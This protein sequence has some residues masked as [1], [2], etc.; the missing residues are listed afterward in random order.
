MTDFGPYHMLSP[1]TKRLR[2]RLPDEALYALALYIYSLKPPLNPNLIDQ[3]SRAGQKIFEREGC[4]RCHTPPLYTNNKLTLAFGFTPG[5]DLSPMLD[6]SPVSVG[7]DPGLALKP[8]KARAT[9]RSRRSEASGTAA[10]ICTMAPRQVW[11]KC[12]IRIG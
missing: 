6:I 9:I 3:K 4:A 8:A 11:R 12:S 1:E 5:K 2:V 7:T 10:I